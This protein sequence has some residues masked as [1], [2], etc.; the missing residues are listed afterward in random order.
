MTN[1]TE[2]QFK[3]ALADRIV[4]YLAL[5]EIGRIEGVESWQRPVK[6]REL[7]AELGST[8][9]YVHE[10]LH[11]LEAEGRITVIVR[12]AGRGGGG[13]YAV[14][15]NWWPAWVLGGGMPV[16]CMPAATQSWIEGEVRI[17]K[18]L[19][20]E[21]DTSRQ[22]NERLARAARVVWAAKLTGTVS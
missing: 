11:R 1:K 14:P 3:F 12:K 10:V 8:H 6:M 20:P 22:R 18:G 13:Y 16:E 21:N 9:P 4:S 15:G 19:E 5:A 17:L 7:A 2:Y